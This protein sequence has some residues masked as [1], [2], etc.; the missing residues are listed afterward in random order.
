VVSA[1][2][3]ALGFVAG[4]L[5]AEKIRKKYGTS[6]FYGRLLSMPELDRKDKEI[7]SRI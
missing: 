6:N 4:I 7:K 3:I 5:F 2:I 1:V